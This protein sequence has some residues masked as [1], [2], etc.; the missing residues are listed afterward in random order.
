MSRCDLRRLFQGRHGSRR[1]RG[2]VTERPRF[3]LG[4]GRP[5][6]SV[7]E[8]LVSPLFPRR[9]VRGALGGCHASFGDI[10]VI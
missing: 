10:E 6:R 3:L 5:I 4:E 9:C 7:R 8:P 2:S 1:G